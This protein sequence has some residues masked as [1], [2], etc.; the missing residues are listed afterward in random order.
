M[1]F[2]A[3]TTFRPH[4]LTNWEDQ[5]VV[6]RLRS[7]V[8]D[9]FRWEKPQNLPPR[10]GRYAKKPPTLVV[11]MEPAQETLASIGE[12][13][14]IVIIDDDDHN[15]KPTVDKH[16]AVPEA[17]VSQALWRAAAVAAAKNVK[18]YA[19]ASSEEDDS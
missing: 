11:T 9:I 16:Q 12:S 15:R 13:A 3:L 4:T 6:V 8:W 17:V 1:R 5:R 18:K 14:T 7:R 19:S 2:K 10:P